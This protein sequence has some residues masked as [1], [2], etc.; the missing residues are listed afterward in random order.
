MP[1]HAIVTSIA[2]HADY[3]TYVHA[4]SVDD[5]DRHA[6]HTG[7]Q[8]WNWNNMQKYIP[9]VRSLQLTSSI[10]SFTR[11]R[12]SYNTTLMNRTRDSLLPPTTTRQVSSTRLPTSHTALSK[13][14]F[15]VSLRPSIRARS[16][17]RRRPPS[18]IQ[19]RI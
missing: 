7:D 4:G 11:S 18:F 10:L 1:S 8:G 15:R 19:T 9:S 17:R 6:S 16:L 14:V 2:S 5:F 3:H 12:S 13:S